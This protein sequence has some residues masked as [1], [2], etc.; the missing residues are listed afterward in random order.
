MLVRRAAGPAPPDGG[1]GW[2]VVLAAFLQSALVFGVIRSFGVFFVEFVEHFEELSGRISWITS[3]GIAVQQFASPVGSALSTRY[4]ARPVIMAGGFFSALGLLL[5]SFATSLVHLYLSIG[6]LSGFGWALVFTPSVASV[7]RYFKKRRTLAT[8]LA[9][10]GVGLSSFAFSP[11]FQFLVNTYAWRGAMMIVAGMS[12]NLVV[13]GAL[14]RPLTLKED[15]PGG[16]LGGPCWKT[17]STLFGLPL[18]SHCP[19][20]RFVL[21]I[22][23]VNTGYF[24]PYVHLV[25][26]ARELE[27]DEYQAAFLMS[28]AAVADLCG[29]LF[30]GWLGSCRSSQLIHLLVVWTFL[31]GISLLL[32]PWGHTYPVLMAISLGYG[33]F[34]GALTPVVFSIVPE[35][36][37][38]EKIFSSMGLL[39]MIESIG[40]LL[41]S[42]LSGCLRDLTGS[43]AASFLAAGAFI[44]AGSLVLMTVPNFSSCLTQ[45]AWQDARASGEAGDG[46]RLASVAP[47]VLPPEKCPSCTVGPVAEQTPLKS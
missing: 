36:V 29:R 20:M 11:L 23:L 7:A 32:I 24:V 35:I 9:L 44:L 14:I 19:F 12:F 42:P 17:V 2:V 34:S 41:G 4:G 3:I 21:A 26:R 25:A 6:L 8:S 10:T 47:A 1:W 22:T 16:G 33:F 31:T 18:L 45:P 39:Q 40:G 46:S 28:L 37:G 43:Y 5:A 13:C 27:F 15:L 38:I 30:S